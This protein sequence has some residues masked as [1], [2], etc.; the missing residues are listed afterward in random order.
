MTGRVRLWSRENGRGLIELADGRVYRIRRADV[1]YEDDLRRGQVIQ[2]E[3]AFGPAGPIARAVKVLQ[4]D[5]R[6]EVRA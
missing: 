4:P 2:F 1:P 5:P 3:P 6:A